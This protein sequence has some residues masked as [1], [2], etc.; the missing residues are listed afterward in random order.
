MASAATR[1][2]PRTRVRSDAS[3]AASVP[4]PMASPRS[5]WASAA[6]SL[7]P[8]PTMATTLPSACSRLTTSTLSAGSTSAITSSM[9]TSAATVRATASLSPVS[10]TG[11]EPEGA[12]PRDRLG[13]GRLDRVGHDQHRARLAVPADR[14]GG[15]ARRPAPAPAR[16]S[17]SAG[18]CCDH[19]AQQLRPADQHRVPVDDALHAEPLDVGEVLDRGSRRPLGGALAM[20][21]AI[22]CS[23]ACSSAPASR[24]TSPRSSPSARWTPTSVIRP[25]VTVPV[26]SSTTCRPRG[27]T[28]APPGP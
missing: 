26:L 1:R 21:W 2:S 18:R 23:E 22:G 5:A 3:I 10:S 19:S 11:V 7:T 25:S 6:A 28:P 13:A 15:T 20:A 14:D 16:R 27:W 8:S 12:Q 17:S 9:P 24:S 4:V